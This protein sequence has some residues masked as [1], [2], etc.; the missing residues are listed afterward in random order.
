[1]LRCG[2]CGFADSISGEIMRT[3][4]GILQIAALAAAGLVGFMGAAN[5]QLHDFDV[6]INQSFNQT[7]DTTADMEQAFFSSRAMFTNSNDYTA[8]GT[9]TIPGGGTRSLTDLG[10]PAELAFQQTFINGSSSLS[11]AQAVYNT[12]TYQFDLPAGNK[13]EA[14]G[15]MSY[16]GDAFPNTPLVTNLSTLQ[17]LNA[18][19]SATFDLNGMMVSP[20]A[21]PDENFIFFY[22]YNASTNAPV[23]SEIFLA[24]TT[25]DIVVNG[26]ILAAGTSYYFNLVY[27]DRIVGTTGGDT[28]VRTTQF[29]DI[30]TTGFFATG[31]SAPVPE[32]ST[33][34]MLVV[35]F[36]GLGFMVRRRAGAVRAKA[37]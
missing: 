21:T 6:G 17:S 25:S 29:Y 32:P 4:R 10:N 30:G 31:G 1:M 24:P 11:D 16:D 26:G 3:L 22:I 2:T 37:A 19:D 14:S 35:G 18:A 12:G 7:S 23:F 28:P 15:Q 27:D 8:P 5:A 36:A 20:N 9:L 34:A 13:P 33:W